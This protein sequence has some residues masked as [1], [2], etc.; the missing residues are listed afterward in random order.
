MAISVPAETDKCL[1]PA[2]PNNLA[3]LRDDKTNICWGK[4]SGVAATKECCKV[5]AQH[6]I[7]SGNRPSVIEA[8]ETVPS[9]GAI[10]S[11][12]RQGIVLALG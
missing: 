8:L 4:T 2:A 5:C 12:R 7:G 9:K 10:N 3:T 1:F 6:N 11:A